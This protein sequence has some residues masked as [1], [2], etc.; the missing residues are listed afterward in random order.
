MDR[1]VEFVQYSGDLMGLVVTANHVVF[2]WNVDHCIILFSMCCQGA[3]ANCHFASNKAGLRY[4]KHCIDKFVR[5]V[6]SRYE[7]CRM[8]IANVSPASVGRLIEKVGFV[9]FADCEKGTFYM[10]VRNELC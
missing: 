2:R 9:P 10:R 7:W 4:I 6:F 1:P 3:S 8:V 5:F